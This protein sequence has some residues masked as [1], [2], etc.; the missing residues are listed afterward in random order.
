MSR[1]T[2]EQNTAVAELAHATALKG[3]DT[4]PFKLERALIAQHRADPRDHTLRLLFRFR[5]GVPAEL[6][7]DSPDIV[8]LSVQEHG[9]VRM[10]RWIEPKPAFR[11]EVRFHHDIRDQESVH[12]DLS[13]GLQPHQ[14]ANGTARSVRR[15]QPAR[16]DGIGA[17]R[18]LD[19]ELDVVGGRRHRNDLV[20]PPQIHPEL[21]RPAELELLEVVL[22]QIHHARPLVI[23]FGD[24]VETVDLLLSEEGPTDNPAD[25]LIDYAIAATDAIE[26]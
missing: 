14:I 13:L 24:E 1:I 8:G 20:L 2:R 16:F 4:H 10:K 11:W 19:L 23:R 15:N 12:E 21:A 3:I 18:R 9:L 5:I 26:H 25:A 6:K 7:I 22:L 17:I